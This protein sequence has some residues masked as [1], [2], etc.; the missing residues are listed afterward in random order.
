M[1]ATDP[2]PETDRLMP[3][4]IEQ[5]PR[6]PKIV[7]LQPWHDQLLGLTDTGEIYRLEMWQVGNPSQW[8]ME[9]DSEPLFSGFPRGRRR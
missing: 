5:V 9:M 7:Q 6:P 8:R 1:G 3:G 4:P 2:K